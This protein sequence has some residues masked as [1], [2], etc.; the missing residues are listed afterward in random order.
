MRTTL[1]GPDGAAGRTGGA[2]AGV[3]C[4]SGGG[5]G[6]AFEQAAAR[7]VKAAQARR[8]LVS[9]TK[10]DLSTGPPEARQV[11]PRRRIRARTER[12]GQCRLLGRFEERHGCHRSKLRLGGHDTVMRSLSFLFLDGLDG[13]ELGATQHDGRD[14]EITDRHQRRLPQADPLAVHEAEEGKRCADQAR[15]RPPS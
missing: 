7:Q 12:V 10:G 9:L 1:K 15:M 5:G 2:G 11:A 4:P 6:V 3:A 13:C 8:D 14:T